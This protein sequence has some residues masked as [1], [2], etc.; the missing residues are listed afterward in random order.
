MLENI[1]IDDC[2]L[3]LLFV[4][5]HQVGVLVD[6]LIDRHILGSGSLLPEIVLLQFAHD[7]RVGRVSNLLIL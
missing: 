4:L 7:E 6:V 2:L 1:I 5:R 3:L